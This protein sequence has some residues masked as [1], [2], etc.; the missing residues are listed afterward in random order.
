MDTT[1]MFMEIDQATDEFV[2]LVNLAKIGGISGTDLQ[3]Q[4]KRVEGL[5]KL[6]ID[7]YGYHTKWERAFYLLKDKWSAS[8]GKQTKKESKKLINPSI[9]KP[10]YSEEDLYILFAKYHEVDLQFED[11]NDNDSEI[12]KIAEIVEDFEHRFEC[13][14]EEVT[15]ENRGNYHLPD[16]DDKKIYLHYL[17]MKYSR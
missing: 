5:M 13:N 1:E 16:F 4:I 15:V 17:N 9:G 8:I 10:L 7:C 6:L 11:K 3:T 14:F 2:K 12:K